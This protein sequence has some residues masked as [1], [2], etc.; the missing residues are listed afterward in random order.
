MRGIADGFIHQTGS[1]EELMVISENPK[2]LVDQLCHRW[3]EG[4]IAKS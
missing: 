2:D 3:T 4:N 1:V